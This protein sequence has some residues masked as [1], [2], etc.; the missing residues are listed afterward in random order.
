MSQ[1]KERDNL[2]N[3]VT[4]D[5]LKS[6]FTQ[7]LGSKARV[8]RTRVD[9]S[10]MEDLRDVLRA[11][12]QDLKTTGVAPKMDYVGSLSIHVYKSEILKQAAFVTVSASENMTFDL[13]DGALRELTGNTLE[14][15]GRSRQKLRSGF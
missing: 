4:N 1:K 5:L 10:R 3:E 11:I 15:Y 12:G 13:A 14:S 6:K 9:N 2:I 8:E 7:S